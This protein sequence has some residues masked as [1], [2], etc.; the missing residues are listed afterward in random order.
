M[1]RHLLAL[2]LL[3]ILPI[4]A[5][6]SDVSYSYIDGGYA[7][8]DWLGERGDG[9]FLDGSV[10]F[11]PNIYG[12]ASYRD[13]SNDDFGL[14]LDETVIGLGYHIPVSDQADLFGEIGYVNVGGELDDVG[15][16]SSD[17]YRF[18][19]GFRG[20]LAPKFEGS[21]RAYYTHLGGDFEG[22]AYGATVG[23]VFHINQTWGIMGSYD[24]T[25]FFEEK[26]NTW[27]V[28]IR[29]SF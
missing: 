19:A 17:G 18:A 6:A 4:S 10:A 8:A 14:T 9:F 24:T 3:S 13:V 1:N 2:C 16:T 22:N 12:F 23:A 20:M 7:S 5:Q 28:G 26:I 21:I 25:E 29:A 15:S 11:N 27:G